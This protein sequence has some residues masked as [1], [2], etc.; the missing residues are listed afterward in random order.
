M[1][2]FGW[3]TQYEHTGIK[4]VIDSNPLRCLCFIKSILWHSLLFNT[5][6]P[7]MN[8]NSYTTSPLGFPVKHRVQPAKQKGNQHALAHDVHAS[9]RQDI[10]TT[11]TMAPPKY[12]VLLPTY[13]ER[14]NLPLIVWLLEKAFREKCVCVHCCV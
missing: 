12:S 4:L 5:S 1:A 14:E 9:R 6:M 3:H 2:T 13:N 10:K 11:T 8:T 7:C